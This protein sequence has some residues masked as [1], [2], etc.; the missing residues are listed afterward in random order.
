[1]SHFAKFAAVLLLAVFAASGQ[2]PATPSIAT[3]GDFSTLPTYLVGVG[4]ELNPAGVITTLAVRIGQ[5][6]LYSWSTM[7]TPV[8]Q[9]PSVPATSTSTA[10][11]ATSQ[12]VSSVR[13]GAAYV[14]AH[15][16]ACFLFFLGDAGFSTG[17]GSTTLGAYS[18]GGGVFCNSKKAP[19][20]YLGP[21]VRAVKI[22][23]STVTPIAEFMAS[24]SF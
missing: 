19:H 17:V 6:N 9:T 4:A 2:T 21:V 22:S 15:S 18:G 16:G 24:W 14:A 8:K 5:S 23:S 12:I 1:M 20:L 10:T 11:P 13:T 3:T 7:D